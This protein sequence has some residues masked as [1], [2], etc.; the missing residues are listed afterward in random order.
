MIKRSEKPPQNGELIPFK[1]SAQ[2]QL[3]QALNGYEKEIRENFPDFWQMYKQPEREPAEI[4]KFK[5]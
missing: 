5:K 3:Q 4:K 1:P 2:V